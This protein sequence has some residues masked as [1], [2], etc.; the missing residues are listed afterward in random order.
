MTRSYDNRRRAGAAAQTRERI[1][2]VTEE[3]LTS[4]GAS[5]VTLKAVADGAEVTVQTVLRHMGSREG[6]LD[7]VRRRV[8]ARVEEQRGV[9]EPGDIAGALAGLMAHYEAEG[10]LILRLL[11][12]EPTD[13]FSQ[14]AVTQGR[15]YHRAWVERCFGPH[16]PTTDREQAIDALVTATDLYGWRLLRLDLGRSLAEAEAV[17]TRLVC[18][19]LGLS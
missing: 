10:A 16:L 17:I 13:S 7:A 14:E 8:A 3:R 5:G 15:A 1:T 9:S 6:C 12:D 11:A 19:T 18:G 2:A 4:V